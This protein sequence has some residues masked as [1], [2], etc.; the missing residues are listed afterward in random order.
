VSP[1]DPDQPDDQS[2]T[3]SDRDTIIGR[4]VAGELSQDSF[5]SLI[6][7]NS[8]WDGNKPAD[9]YY[10]LWQAYKDAWTIV[11]SNNIRERLR[12]RDEQT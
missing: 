12:V 6:L 7:C 2:E 10:I 11:E 5:E 9:R 8:D 4:F 3:Q 1:F